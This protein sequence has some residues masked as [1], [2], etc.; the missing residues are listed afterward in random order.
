MNW[1]LYNEERHL[2]SLAASRAERLYQEY[3]SGVARGQMHAGAGPA[4]LAD[5]GWIPGMAEAP[6]DFGRAEKLA[7]ELS[8]GMS[9]PFGYPDRAEFQWGC[10][11]NFVAAGISL[12]RELA[13]SEVAGTYSPQA[14]R[15]A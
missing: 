2:R 3:L 4:E 14:A 10:V 1:L 6:S 12:G 7:T 13:M 8:E 5:E 9:H 15:G 11:V